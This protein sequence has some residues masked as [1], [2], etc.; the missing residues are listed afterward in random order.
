MEVLMVQVLS[1]CT[2]KLF[3]HAVFP[4]VMIKPRPVASANDD[5]PLAPLPSVWQ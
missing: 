5:D 2:A 1:Y 3:S 4:M